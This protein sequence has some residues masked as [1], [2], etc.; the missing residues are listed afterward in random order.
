[1]LSFEGHHVEQLNTTM[2]FNLYYTYRDKSNRE[3]HH[4]FVFTHTHSVGHK[5]LAQS[6]QYAVAGTVDQEEQFVRYQEI[7][8]TY[9]IYSTS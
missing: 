4:T 8:Y 7:K 9:L 2:T 1:M 3:K 5:Y 6:L